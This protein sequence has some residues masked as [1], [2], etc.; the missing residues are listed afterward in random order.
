MTGFF[1]I[2]IER[3]GIKPVNFDCLHQL[4][5]HLSNI[6]LHNCNFIHNRSLLRA[7]SFSKFI[8]TTVLSNFNDLQYYC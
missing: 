5:Y 1:G 8:F 4:V 2:N 7:L 3:L 6:H